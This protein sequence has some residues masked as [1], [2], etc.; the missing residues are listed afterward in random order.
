MAAV[1]LANGDRHLF[2]Q[3]NTGLIR[4]AVRTASNGQWSTSPQLNASANPKNH[5][6][7]AA[8]IPV[9]I[10]DSLSNTQVHVTSEKSYILTHADLF[11]DWAVLCFREQYS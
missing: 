7:L 9:G 11:L 5:T 3:D 8:I 6:P 1:S 10:V 2:F 4:R